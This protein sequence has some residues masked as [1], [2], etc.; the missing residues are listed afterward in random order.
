M[1]FGKALKI[2][3]NE[4]AISQSSL[5]TSI[6]YTQRAISKWVN[7]QSEPTETAIRKVATYF[8]VSTDYLMGTD[9]LGAI[10]TTKDTFNTIPM[11]QQLILNFRKLPPQ[12][13]EYVFGIVQNLATHS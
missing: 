2:L 9:D 13:Q 8:N 6:G 1:N 12:S 11:E 3:M 7:E 4:H 5:A 10:I